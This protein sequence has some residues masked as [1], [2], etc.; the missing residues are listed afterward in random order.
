MR[1]ESSTAMW[2]MSLVEAGL[3][4]DLDDGDV[5]AERVASSPGVSKS[6]LG[7]EAAAPCPR[8]ARRGRPPPWPARAH[9]DRRRR[10]ARHAEALAG[11]D[12]D[13]VGGGLEQVRGELAG[14]CRA[15]R[16]VALI[17]ALPPT[18]SEREPIVPMPRGD[19]AVSDWIDADVVHRDAERP[20]DELR[21]RRLVALAVRRGAGL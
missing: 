10:R 7:V 15:P 2:R 3:G 21:A 11:D 13:V 5:G 6:L 18:C 16:R 12:L 20:G 19:L 1:P 4:V 17:I 8:A 14:P 9:G